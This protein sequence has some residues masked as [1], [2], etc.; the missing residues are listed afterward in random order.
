MGTHIRVNDLGWGR[1]TVAYWAENPN[2]RLMLFVHG[3]CGDSM[4][5]WHDFQGMLPANSTR[6]RDSDIVFFGYDSRVT[7][8]ARNTK[9]LLQVL[10]SLTGN[11]SQVINLSID[12]DVEARKRKFR[13]TEILLVAHSLGAVLCRR[14]LLEARDKLKKGQKQFGWVNNVRMVL[15]APAHL[16]ARKLPLIGAGIVNA[17]TRIDT[18]VASQLAPNSP[19]IVKLKNDTRQAV[20]EGDAEYLRAAKVILGAKDMVVENGMYDG[21]HACI[22]IA[23]HGHISVCKPSG[24]YR[25]PI[26][27]VG[28]L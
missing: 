4:S 16:G 8:I 20:S 24:K 13:F 12:N 25:D 3:F 2:G 27:Q 6:C 15:F 14:A 11:P 26:D 28:S 1:Q 19:I 9:V 10:Q 17:L 21:D 18:S 7:D 5:T 22:T 23:G